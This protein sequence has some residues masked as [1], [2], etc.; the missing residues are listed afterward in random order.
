MPFLYDMAWK[1]ANSWT[2]SDQDTQLDKLCFVW[3]SIR[4]CLKLICCQRGRRAKA[5]KLSDIKTLNRNWFNSDDSSFSF[6]Q[7]SVQILRDNIFVQ[8]FD[9]LSFSSLF[10]KKK[11]F[12]VFSS[13]SVFFAPKLEHVWRLQFNARPSCCFYSGSNF[14]TFFGI[15]RLRSSNFILIMTER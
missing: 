15:K 5:S 10:L 9:N 1:M 12:V 7:Q 8:F 6:S 11:L 14:T 4:Q 13:R 2:D 3:V